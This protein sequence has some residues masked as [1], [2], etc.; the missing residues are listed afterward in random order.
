MLRLL[1]LNESNI[2][3]I[4]IVLFTVGLGLHLLPLTHHY[5]L[6]ITDI[7][8][9]FTNSLVLYFVFREQENKTL[10]IWS[11]AALILTFV[12]EVIGVRTGMIF[13]DYHYGKTMMIQFF[14]VPVV[15]GMNWVLLILGTYSI[16]QWLKLK[17]V[18][19]PLVSS[20]LIVGFDFI[21]EK[22]AVRL[23]YWQWEGNVIPIRNYISWFFISLIFTSILS[24]LKVKI[25][26]RLLKIYFIVQLGFFIGL[27]LFLN[28]VA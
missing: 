20:V 23:D 3:V 25:N 11:F 8:M 10:I 14:E 6:A 21:M 7:F 24:L 2:S 18:F 16:S 15:I 1:K 28:G 26:N 12:I 5:V 27:R 22:V 13:G 4:I 19:V 17:H 9:L